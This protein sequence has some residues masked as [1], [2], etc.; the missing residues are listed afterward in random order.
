MV[1]FSFLF[2]FDLLFEIVL[3]LS[4]FLCRVVSL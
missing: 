4:K 3:D 2:L 1:K